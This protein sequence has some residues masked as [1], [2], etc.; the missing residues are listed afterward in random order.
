MRNTFAKKI[1]ELTEKDRSI[2]LLTGD[3]GFSVFEEFKDRFPGN[4]INCGVAEQN[5]IGM[6]AGLA[7]KG[8]KVF[9]YSIIPFITYRVLEH[10]RNDLA[11]QRLPVK[12]IGVGTGLSYANQGSSHHAIEDIGVMSSIP[13]LY[14]FSPG[15][16]LETEKVLDCSLNLELP[17][18]IRLNKKQDP[19]I[20]TEETIKHFKRGEPLKVYEKGKDTVIFAMGN[21]LP[22]GMEVIKE[23]EEEGVKASLYSFHTVKPCDEEG[24]INIIKGKGTVVTLEEHINRNGL[25][26]IFASILIKRGLAKKFLPFY[27]PDTFIHE[28][29]SQD[30]YRKKFGLNK[31]NIV[32]KIKEELK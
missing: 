26:S 14:I 1:M 30:Y 12:I 24:L 11:Y 7:L 4:Y 27:L 10:I 3:L 15:D 28:V 23:L 8:K 22:V 20:H 16:P 25:F 5:M 19:L 31:E 2:I 6:A 32:K 9:V 21:M 13:D 17:C 29:G 18:Y